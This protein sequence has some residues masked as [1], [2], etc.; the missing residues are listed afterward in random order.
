[1]K[2]FDLEK[3]LAGEPVRLRNG[4][5]AF[6]KYQIPDEFHTE[7]PLSGYFLKSFLGRIRAN[8]QSWR[9]NGKVN[10]SLEHDEDIVSMW[11]EPNPRVQLDLPCPL[12]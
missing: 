8:R 10:Q 5:K 6:V 3:A 9:L 11:Q 4:C 1:M 2:P 7:S 12:K